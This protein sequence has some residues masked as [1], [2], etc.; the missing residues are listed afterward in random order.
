[1]RALGL[2]EK[3][4]HEQVLRIPA[5]RNDCLQLISH[6]I[7]D[8][9]GLDTIAQ[10]GPRSRY[11]AIGHGLQVEESDILH[12]LDIT[13]AVATLSKFSNSA[14]PTRSR[15]SGFDAPLARLGAFCGMTISL[16]DYL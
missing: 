8:P 10:M 14:S 16:V 1:M 2:E 12:L 13:G 11:L 3:I 15:K 7:L 9:F 6:P 5:R 4:G